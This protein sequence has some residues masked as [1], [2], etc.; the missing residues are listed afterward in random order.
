[1]SLINDALKRAKQAQRDAGTPADGP[2]LRPAYAPRRSE[3]DWLLPVLSGVILL[4]G[5]LLLWQWFQS[6]ARA[7]QVR[8]NTA[9]LETAAV[10]PPSVPAA[11][12]IPAENP[13]SSEVIKGAK[14]TEATAIA[15]TTA[16]P[17]NAAPVAAAT[18]AAPALPPAPTYKLQSLFFRAKNPCAVINGK[19]VFV[20]DHVA[21]AN[22]V[23]IDKYSATLITPAGETKVLE[24]Q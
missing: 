23:A 14:G 8:A 19:T 7:M 11:M 1:M 3:T 21:G 12:P 9:P 24:L 17:T 10:Q 6:G 15:P 16:T 22:V 13:Q 18:P 20:G 5:V 2:D 4:L